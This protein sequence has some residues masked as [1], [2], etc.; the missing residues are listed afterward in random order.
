MTERAFL[1]LVEGVTGLGK[2]TILDR[3]VRRHV[4]DA[5]ERKL[6]TVLHL[7]QA[8]TYGPLAP[9]EDAG[10]LT[11]DANLAHLE[12]IVAHLEW[13]AAT[14]AAEAVAKCFAL[15][16]TLHLTHCLRP[17]A[18]AWDDVGPYDQRL[19][20]AGCRLLLLDAED[21]TVRERCVAARAETDFIRGYAMRRFATDLAGLERR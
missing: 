12:R 19:A 13:L 7:T 21:A 14:V 2:S 20:D 9:A 11:R 16:D 6:R 8:H 5:P 3:L 18:V 17:G 10:T 4:A 1:L 15:V